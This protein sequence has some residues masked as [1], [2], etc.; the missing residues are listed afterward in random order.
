[1]LTITRL[2]W[3]SLPK[4]SPERAIARIAHI[5]NVNTILGGA[6]ALTKAKRAI[7]MNLPHAYEMADAVDQTYAASTGRTP[8]EYTACECPECGS[9]HLGADNAL[10]CCCTDECADDYDSSFDIDDE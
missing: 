7:A 1:M 5:A 9:I 6:S 2:H 8:D 4:G 3:D 10:L